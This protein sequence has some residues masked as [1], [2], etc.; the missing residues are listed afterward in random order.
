MGATRFSSDLS[1]EFFHQCFGMCGSLRMR[2]L[3]FLSVCMSESAVSAV[4]H[5][6]HGGASGICQMMPDTLR[7][8]GFRGDGQYL[9]S[10]T[11]WERADDATKSYLNDDLADA[12]RRLR[13][14]EQLTWVDRYYRPAIGRLGSLA[15]VYV[16]NFLPSDMAL[17]SDPESVLIAR[18]GSSICPDGRRSN[19]FD[20]N[21]G[22]DANGDKA[23]Q[24]KELGAAVERACHGP[25]WV[26]IHDRAAEV[27][28]EPPLAP[29]PSATDLDM[30]SVLGIQLAM[31]ALGMTIVADGIM[32]A[33][34]VGAI[35]SFQMS[36]G[37]EPDGLAGP[38]TRDA[39]EKA[40][41]EARND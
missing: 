26:E 1:D 31:Q 18:F 20:V 7:R 8:L 35:R 5:N 16:W 30:R 9:E 19:L 2:M 23:I 28:G 22:F 14:D 11:S 17:A 25:R 38:K 27:L 40:Y 13:A 6:P 41:K 34:T 36:H 37:L 21:H 4:A 33:E 3:D 10:T 15:A 24:V 39:L 12:F 32:G 29:M